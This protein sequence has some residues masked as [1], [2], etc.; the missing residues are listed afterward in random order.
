MNPITIVIVAH[1]RADILRSTLMGLAACQKPVS[2]R[3]TI[4][5]E[6]GPP[7]GIESVVAEFQEELCI[8]HL[9]I[10][11]P[12][13]TV[14]LNAAVEKAETGWAIFIDD[15]VR[16]PADWIM[17]YARAFEQAPA[18][19]YFGGPTR[20]DYEEIPPDW[21]LH[22]LPDS[23]RGLK[24][25]AGTTEICFPS[26]FLGF[27]WAASVESI[28]LAHGYP[29]D[30]G[31]GTSYGVADESLMQQSLCMQGMRG[32]LIPEAIV[33]HQI[34]KD[35]C[36][37]DWCLKRVFQGARF[38]GMVAAHHDRKQKRRLAW[39]RSYARH[40]RYRLRS[41]PRL[42][43]FRLNAHGRFWISRMWTSVRGFHVGYNQPLDQY[44]F[45]NN[46]FPRLNAGLTGLA[47]ETIVP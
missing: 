44:S 10:S 7:C 38:A 4:L 29:I 45:T 14:A 37:P 21:L 40:F 34:P 25:P 41:I 20:C 5:A 9:R 46:E 15:D 13:K 27:N 30:F 11:D 31:P 18:G 47:R 1:G 8:E 22:Y 3:G 32:R 35:R 28:K 24:F 12:R 23:A 19:Y 16:V 33:W 42:E 36:S 26:F 2:F 39:A 43:V 6:N 17:H